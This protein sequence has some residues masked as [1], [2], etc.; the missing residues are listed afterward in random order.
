[1]QSYRWGATAVAN[2]GKA[3]A[4][5]GKGLKPMRFKILSREAD[6]T[7]TD[8]PRGS[9]R[10]TADALQRSLFHARTVDEAIGR[11]DWNCLA[12]CIDRNEKLIPYANL[13]QFIARILRGEQPP[14]NRRPTEEARVRD[15]EMA[16]MSRV[17]EETMSTA[18]ALAKVA[19]VFDVKDTRT[20]QKAR[21]E[22]PPLTRQ[23]DVIAALKELH[24]AD[25]AGLIERR[26]G[27]K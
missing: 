6:G 2:N 4:T 23:A 14:A 3:K 20:V 21:A 8:F 11:A 19:Q 17:L 16:M 13:R 1:V 26:G 25:E 12:D 22:Y 27:T 7:E 5:R 9:A 10:L 15:F 18:D 24:L